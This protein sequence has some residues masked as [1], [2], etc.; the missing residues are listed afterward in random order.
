V[1]AAIALLALVW[2]AARWHTTD[3]SLPPQSRG[4]ADSPRSAPQIARTPPRQQPQQES[5]AERGESARTA[6]NGVEAPAPAPDRERPPFDAAA[7]TDRAQG[8]ALDALS[9]LGPD[10]SPT[11]LVAALNR[12][13]ITFAPESAA[14]T[15]KSREL[16]ERAAA[17]ILAAPSETRIEI[18]GHTDSLGVERRNRALSQARAEAVRNTLVELGV[19]RQMLIPR[20][21]GSSRPVADDATEEGR[22]R[23]R[24]IE[25]AVV[26]GV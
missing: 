5:A 26:G 8:E 7:A 10:F 9:A 2:L 4:D 13:A 21:Y 12:G 11:D 22:F 6:A 25:F 3:E 1:V 23:N 24:R 20:G 19:P 15:R 14:V 17:T 16:L 18:A